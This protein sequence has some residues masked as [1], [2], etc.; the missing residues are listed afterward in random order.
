MDGY[1]TRKIKP[2]YVKCCAG[3]YTELAK[4]K[5]MYPAKKH[6]SGNIRQKC[7]FCGQFLI[8][9]IYEVYDRPEGETV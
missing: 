5:T 3:C 9:D 7:G 8:C 6:K 1:V 4:L 2:R